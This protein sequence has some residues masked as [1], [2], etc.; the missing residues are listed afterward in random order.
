MLLADE[1]SLGLAPLVVERLLI[2]LRKAADNGLGVLLV[3]QHVRKALKVAD[4][5]YVLQR[6]RIVYTGT[7]EEARRDIDV[8]EAAYLGGSGNNVAQV[9]GAA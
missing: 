5:V 2:A 7:G 8:I 3:E 1:L 4:R 9:G 6:G